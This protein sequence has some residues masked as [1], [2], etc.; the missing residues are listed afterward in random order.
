[1]L[2]MKDKKLII[3]DFD[4]VIIDSETLHLRA[5]NTCLKDFDIQIT[6][7]EYFESYISFDD[8]GVISK[9]FKNN[10]IDVEDGRI[11]E[12][13]NEKNN[14]YMNRLVDNCKIFDGV[15]DLIQKLSK[16]FILAIGSGSN[17]AEILRVL[18]NNALDK[19]FEVIV[20]SDEVI[21][22][23]P[24]PETY[25]RV[26]EQ[27]NLN[28]E[29]TIKEAIVIEDTPGG[30]LAAKSCG[31]ECI[32]ITNTFNRDKLQLADQVFSNYNDIHKYL[33]SSKQTP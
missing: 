21:N 14:F 29:I 1:M 18:K 23:K 8:Y 15:Y 30:I 24:N 12:L 22:P 4:G 26:I 25:N 7:A 20:S 6:D 11:N 32:G 33:L 13:I 2:Y 10:D 17:R 3:F 31:I 5:F 28:N 9:H 16:N 19:Y 27:I